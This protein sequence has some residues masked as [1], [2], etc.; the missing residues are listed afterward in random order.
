M[1]FGCFLF[2]VVTVVIVVWSKKGVGC[3]R[4]EQECQ[5]KE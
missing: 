3:L 5:L 1:V 4:G 2:T